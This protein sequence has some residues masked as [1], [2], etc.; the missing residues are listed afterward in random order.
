MNKELW[1]LRVLIWYYRQPLL[2]YAVLFIIALCWGLL[3]HTGETVVLAVLVAPWLF[4]LLIV[5]NLPF[6]G[7]LIARLRLN[8]AKRQNHALEHG[9]IHCWLRRQSTKKKVGGR[10]ESEGFR[11]S[12][13]GSENEI[14][15]AFSEFLTLDEKERWST[16][17]S[18]RCGSM[19]VI[20]QGNRS[21]FS[22]L[23]DC[24]IHLLATLSFC[25]RHGPRDSVFPFFSTQ[26]PP[27]TTGAKTST[28][29]S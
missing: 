17:V 25:S 18:N 6:I 27:G 21:Y 7:G 20:A 26:A 10:A 16:A 8:P 13:I 4:P 29:L 2:G 14:R 12:G 23:L 28:S 22:T 19:L 24:C 1:P 9:T 3:P 11:V 15:K 5:L